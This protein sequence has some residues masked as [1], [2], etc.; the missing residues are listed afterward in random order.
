LD[1]ALP[2]LQNRKPAALL[3]VAHLICERQSGGV[4]APGYLKLNSESYPT[5]S[6]KPSVS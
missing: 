6:S 4:R 5:S 3:V 2:L 1:C